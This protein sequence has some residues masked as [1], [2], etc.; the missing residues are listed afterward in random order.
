MRRNN[1]GSAV[2]EAALMMPWLAFLFVGILDFG[3]YAYASIC[4]QNAARAAAVAA[5]T[6]SPTTACVAALGEL[7]DLPNIP[8]STCAT[9]PSGLG[10]GTVYS[11]CTTLIS[12]TGAVDKSCSN[13]TTCADC[14]GNGGTSC[15][16]CSSVQATVAYQTVPMIP[17]PGVLMGRM[18]LTRTAEMRVIR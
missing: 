12:A 2:V 5:A 4:T 17:I 8:G 10:L 9:Y 15:T 1:R 14:S 3:F 16:A 7:N 11:A 6:G 18:T 13:A